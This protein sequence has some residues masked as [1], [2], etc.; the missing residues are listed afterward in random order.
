M[1][2]ATGDLARRKLLPGLLH[3]FQAGLLPPGR[4]VGTSLEELRPGVVRRVHPRGRRRVQRPPA[5]P[6]TSGT[7]SR[8]CCATC[9]AAGGAAAL[10]AA[11]E[12]AEA[13]LDG[14]PR[15]L[16]YLSVPPKAALAV[17]RLLDEA[18]AGRAQPDHHGEA[19]RHRPGVGADAERRAARGVRRGADLPHRP[20]PRQGGG[21]EHPG[22]P[23]R[24]RA[25]RADLEPQPHRPRA[26]RRA[27]DARARARAPSSTRPPAP[28]ATW[29]SPTCSRCWRSWRWSR[30]P[31]WSRG[32]SARR[33]T[34]S[35]AR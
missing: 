34:R 10:R 31:R 24:Q 5:R 15:R 13:E 14:E 18:E 27:G 17:V 22:L 30:R 7:P 35:S 8:P 25:V 2:G 12:E 4:I 19:V 26:D 11:V 6:R 29:W 20:L 32:R 21:A 28:T 23:V 9:P 3:L 1:F 16:H 33:R